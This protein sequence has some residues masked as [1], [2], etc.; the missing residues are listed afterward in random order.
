M[1]V[2]TTSSEVSYIGNGVAVAFAVPFRYL[3]EDDLVVTRG[4]APLVRGVDYTVTAPGTSGTVTLTSALGAGLVLAIR[5]NTA[6][7]QATALPTQGPFSPRALE[8]GLDRAILGLQEEERERT[9]VAARAAVLEA[10]AA[11]EALARAVGDASEAAARA[12]GDGAVLSQLATQLAAVRAE[13]DSAPGSTVDARTVVAAGTTTARTLAQREADIP[14]LLDFGGSNDGATSNAT[15]VTAAEASGATRIYLPDGEYALPDGTVLTKEYVGPGKFRFDQELLPATTPTPVTEVV[16]RATVL[17]DLRQF[18]KAVAARACTVAFMGDSITEGVFETDYASSWAGLLGAELR[19]RC[20]RVAW[21]IHNLSLAGLGIAQAMDAGYVGSP[22]GTPIGTGFFRRKGTDPAYATT[23]KDVGVSVAMPDLWPNGSSLGLTWLDHVSAAAPDLFIIALGQ[24]DVVA[25]SAYFAAALKSVIAFARTWP[26]PPSIAIVTTF[27]P[28]RKS[29]AWR[30][31]AANIQLMADTARQ[32][33]LETDCTLL[34]A[35]RLYLLLRDGVDV[36]APRMKRTA[37]FSDYPGSWSGSIARPALVGNTITFPGAGRL[38]SNRQVRDGQV[39]ARFTPTAGGTAFGLIYRTNSGDVAQTYEAQVNGGNVILYYGATNLGSAAIAPIG[40]G[41]EAVLDV[42]FAGAKHE[43]RLNGVLVLTVWD[44]NRLVAGAHG[45]MFDGAGSVAGLS[46]MVGD[47]R[48]VGPCVL[49]E[50]E[51]LGRGTADYWT[52][53]ETLGGDAIHHPSQL[54]HYATLFSAA[55]PL[56]D[57][58]ERVYSRGGAS[59][60]TAAGAAVAGALVGTD[61]VYAQVGAVAGG[62]SMVTGAAGSLSGVAVTMQVV[63]VDDGE[64]VTVT[65]AKNAGTVL[66]TATLNF[67]QAGTYSVFVVGTATDQGGTQRHAVQAY[68]VRVA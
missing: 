7:E 23:A 33:A 35:N 64:A 8:A 1:T 45:L 58:A 63:E 51:L 18:Y 61:Y 12:A 44:Y 22:E 27:P 56:V 5:R 14:T 42:R 30:G 6:R 66:A 37:G 57:A 59:V 24:N 39:Q 25:S 16:R 52:N 36:A 53:D 19:R 41:V 2:A 65:L 62:A 54:G 3:D 11:A 46:L 40:A 32:V 31:H 29:A 50:D 28:T 17:G 15:A 48:R 34:D 68:A 55:L 43:V 67:A 20:P 47:T 49:T 21:D 9:A 38:Y 10:G 60:V 4:N 13:L 26:K